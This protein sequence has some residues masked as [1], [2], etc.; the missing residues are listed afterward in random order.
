MQCERSKILDRV[1]VLGRGWRLA[2]LDLLD[3]RD[4]FLMCCDR[5]ADRTAALDDDALAAELDDHAADA[6]ILADVVAREAARR[7]DAIMHAVDAELRP[8]LAPQIVGHLA[9]IDGADHRP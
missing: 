2:E 6:L 4:Q 3:R 1:E 5:Q 8:A 7:R 9:G